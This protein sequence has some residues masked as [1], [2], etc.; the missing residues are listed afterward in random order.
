MRQRDWIQWSAFAV[1]VELHNMLIFLRNSVHNYVVWDRF[2]DY[3]SA[4]LEEFDSM[5]QKAPDTLYNALL[6]ENMQLTD[7][8]KVNRAIKKLYK[9]HKC[10]VVTARVRFSLS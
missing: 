3:D 7:I 6:R 10:A 8:F 1:H 4:M 2:K 5:R 9:C